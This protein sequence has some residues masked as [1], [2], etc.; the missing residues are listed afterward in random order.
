MLNI[1]LI[2][3]KLKIISEI[4][5]NGYSE[6]NVKF[7]IVIKILE[8]F[9]H[10]D[11][12]DLEHSYGTDRPD[13]IITKYERPIL[14]EIK[15]S[16]EKL[17]AHIEQIKRYSYNLDACLS[18]ITNGHEFLMFSPFWDRKNFNKRLLLSFNLKDLGN[19]EIVENLSNLLWHELDYNEFI[20]NR[21][22]IETKIEN[23]DKEISNYEITK[24][25]YIEEKNIINDKVSDI[26]SLKKHMD[27]LDPKIKEAI[28]KYEDF[29]NKIHDIDN[30]IDILIK[31]VPQISHDE[32]FIKYRKNNNL[33]INIEAE[34]FSQGISDE[35]INILAIY[36]GKQIILCK[37]YEKKNPYIFLLPKTS[38][39]SD[40]TP[41]PIG[42][43]YL[44]QSYSSDY[45][46]Y[47]ANIQYLKI[48]GRNRD[49][50]KALYEIEE[51]N[52]WKIDEGPYKYFTRSSKKKMLLWV[53]KVYKMPFKMY[54]N[55][56]FS[57]HMGNAKIENFETLKR[58]QDGF[59]NK[60]FKQIIN[61]NIFI[62]RKNKIEEIIRKYS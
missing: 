41:S 56:D 16:Q 42:N 20:S 2:I 60:E 59:K 44:E 25:H 28:K 14:I 53:F 23:I 27:Y 6:E 35:V 39:I 5:I 55:K 22:K 58:M 31:Q 17:S 34:K 30:K 12:L 18:I 36:K 37:S 48:P 19:A 26:K 7:H 24:N 1:D 33:N 4:N 61:D 13:I 21:N 8:I 11:V 32:I 52:L 62:E 43:Q 50:W 46:E 51:F 40:F 3:G 15:G 54:K 38:I 47:V 45:C 29:E 10:S 49:F 57:I 9:G